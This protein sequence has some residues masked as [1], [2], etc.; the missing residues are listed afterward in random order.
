MPIEAVSAVGRSDQFASQLAY[1]NSSLDAFGR[2]E[3][4]RK[5]VPRS[6]WTTGR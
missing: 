1:R 5:L 4:M 2:L 3:H 6:G